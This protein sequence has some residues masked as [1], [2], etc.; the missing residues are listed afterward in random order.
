MF[1]A[2]LLASG[3]PLFCDILGVWHHNGNLHIVFFL[4][5]SVSK[6]PFFFFKDIGYFVLGAHSTPTPSHLNLT[7]YI[8]NYPTYK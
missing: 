4:C 5:V 1:H 6:F 2:S 7:N 8:H 3:W